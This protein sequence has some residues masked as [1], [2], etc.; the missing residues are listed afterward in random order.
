M[1]LNSISR[2]PFPLP[3]PVADSERLEGILQHELGLVNALDNV[4]V[5]TAT[6]KFTKEEINKADVII[7][8]TCSIRDHA[9]QKLYDALGP[10]RARK[11]RTETEAFAL[12]VTGCV[13]QQ[14]GLDLLRKIP[15]IDVVLGP[16]YVPYLGEVLAKIEWGYQFCLT[17]PSIIVDNYKPY[18]TSNGNRHRT[19]TA[20]STTATDERSRST[21]HARTEPPQRPQQTRLLPENDDFSSKPIRGH[22]VRSWVNVIYGC[23]E[24]CTY[25]V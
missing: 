24:H 5:T 15:E 11:R 4:D 16:Q 17:E 21:T 23:N 14:E 20:R 18:T 8:N 13:A 12:I 3:T 10:F 19:T 1:F 7:F 6:T 22:T 9:E 25:C 2:I